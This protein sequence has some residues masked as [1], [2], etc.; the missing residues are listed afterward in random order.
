MDPNPIADVVAFV[1]QPGRMNAV[2][3][4]LLAAGGVIAL[5]VFATRPEQRRFHHVLRWASRLLIGA[6]WW[7]QSLWQLPPHYTD[8]PSQPF[9][10]TGLGYVMTQMGRHAAF[11]AQADF[12]N[13]IAL[14]HFY[15]VAPLVY[16]L[17]VLIAVSLMLGACVRLFGVIGAL[18]ILNLWLGLYSAP[19]AWPWAYFFLLV[20][21][22]IFAVD[23]YGRSL[24]I[25]TILFAVRPARE[26]ASSGRDA[27]PR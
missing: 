2:F 3:C 19:G 1:T 27:M 18:Q 6:M 13:H 23:L 20:L 21:Q 4:G 9:G 10:A 11:P 24:G 26:M 25:D 5:Y 16:G 15:L 17:D 8:Q 12:I 7:Q 22:M 14:P